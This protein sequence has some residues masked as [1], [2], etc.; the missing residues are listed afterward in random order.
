MNNSSLKD[1]SDALRVDAISSKVMDHILST[2][3][4]K[5]LRSILLATMAFAVAVNVGG[6]FYAGTKMTSI[7]DQARKAGEGIAR[8]LTEVISE[9]REVQQSSRQFH[10]LIY[11][12]LEGTLKVADKEISDA[13]GGVVALAGHEEERVKEIAEEATGKFNDK[14]AALEALVEA[15]TTRIS[16]AEKLVLEKADS[17]APRIDDAL[18][19]I[20]GERNKALRNIRS[21]SS[22][23]LSD[24][25]NEMVALTGDAKSRTEEAVREVESSIV[26]STEL[27]NE[28]VLK[29]ENESNVALRKLQ[30]DSIDELD[31]VRK[32]LDALSKES[33]RLNLTT[34]RAFLDLEMLVIISFS[35]LALLLS[36]W[37]LFRTREKVIG[38]KDG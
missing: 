15:S 14:V 6:S 5:I 24:I 31:T 38:I 12:K 1:E 32:Q 16:D 18:T 33:G 7:R 26:P 27:I 37:S 13:V 19:F 28:A 20:E 35:V 9:S 8:A 4:F 23:L 36:V 11:E 29:I 17:A 10:S 21:E 34:I 3:S 22:G 2:P 25:Q 30:I